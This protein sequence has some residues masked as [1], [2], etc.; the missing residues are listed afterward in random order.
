MA[1]LSSLQ[2]QRYLL[3]RVFLFY[4]IFFN[5]WALLCRNLGWMVT[6]DSIWNQPGRQEKSIQLPTFIPSF[7]IFVCLKRLCSLRLSLE[8][9]SRGQVIMEYGVA[10]VSHLISHSTVSEGALALGFAVWLPAAWHLRAHTCLCLPRFILHSF[11]L[12][13]PLIGE[14]EGDS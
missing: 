9:F 5:C 4:F 8:Y 11:G 2:C 12:R 14:H 10:L 13:F 3:S 6:S 7:A 1:E